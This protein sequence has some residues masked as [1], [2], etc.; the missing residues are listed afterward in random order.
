CQV[1]PVPNE[2]ASR[3]TMCPICAKS[4]NKLVQMTFQKL[5]ITFWRVLSR[6]AMGCLK[7]KQCLQP[8]SG[9]FHPIQPRPWWTMMRWLRPLATYWRR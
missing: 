4:E 8:K 2:S 5:S 3:A 6:G 9:I 1:R 7:I